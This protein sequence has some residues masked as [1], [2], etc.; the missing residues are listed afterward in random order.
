VPRRPE[1][2]AAAFEKKAASR[3]SITQRGTP[4]AIDALPSLRFTDDRIARAP[5]ASLAR[6]AR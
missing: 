1:R 3:W 4:C 2:R 6:R 5:R